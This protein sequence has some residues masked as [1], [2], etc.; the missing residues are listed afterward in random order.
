MPNLISL[1]IFGCHVD[2]KDQAE[3]IEFLRYCGSFKNL[4]HLSGVK[5]QIYSDDLNLAKI[6]KVVNATITMKSDLT[7]I[8][9]DPES[10]YIRKFPGKFAELRVRNGAQVMTAIQG[11]LLRAG[12]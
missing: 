5:L 7:I 1:E 3:L 8:N 11:R 2:M 6:M 12:L 4:I 9:L 10:K